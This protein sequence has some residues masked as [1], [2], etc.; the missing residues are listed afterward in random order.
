MKWDAQPKK[1]TKGY[2]LTICTHLTIEE[3]ALS[4]MSM[5][6]KKKWKV[7]GVERLL[8]NEAEWLKWS[9]QSC[10]R[11]K[12]AAMWFKKII[13]DKIREDGGTR[14]WKVMLAKQMGRNLQ[15]Q[16]QKIKLATAGRPFAFLSTLTMLLEMLQST[17]PK[18]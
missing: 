13:D 1:A 17:W 15:L 18:A 6:R 2:L 12:V 4:S 5:G 10:H 14:H 7:V 9:M 8:R 11:F 3:E 16:L